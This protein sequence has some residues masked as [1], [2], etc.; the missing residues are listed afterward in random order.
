MQNEAVSVGVVADY[1]GWCGGGGSGEV[2]D[3]YVVVGGGF[4]IAGRV[5]VK[6]AGVSAAVFRGF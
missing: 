6:F 4:E 5:Q 3:V 2:A 1:G